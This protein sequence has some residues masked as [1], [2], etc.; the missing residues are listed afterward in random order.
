MSLLPIA[1]FSPNQKYLDI[2]KLKSGQKGNYWNSLHITNSNCFLI[3][4]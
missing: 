4:P 3:I 1:Y 2:C